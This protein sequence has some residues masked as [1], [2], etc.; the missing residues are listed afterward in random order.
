MAQVHEHYA[1]P[2][3]AQPPHDE[4]IYTANELHQRNPEKH[5]QVDLE[6]NAGIDFVEQGTRSSTDPSPDD[7]DKKPK[8]KWA[9]ASI[10]RRWRLPI[11][12][13]IGLLLTA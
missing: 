6:K 4:P 3:A 13:V 12:I 2:V 10:Y 1:P 8:S 9:P 5:G 7:E 11:H